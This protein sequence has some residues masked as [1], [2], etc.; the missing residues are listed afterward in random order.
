LPIKTFLSKNIA[1]PSQYLRETLNIMYLS[2][3]EESASS[4][5]KDRY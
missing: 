4:C 2:G 1:I 3:T 5:Q